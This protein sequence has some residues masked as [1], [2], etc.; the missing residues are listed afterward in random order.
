MVR[1]TG[2]GTAVVVF[3][4]EVFPPRDW[5]DTV[6]APEA[7]AEGTIPPPSTVEGDRSQTDR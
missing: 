1:R 2:R 6:R 5:R 4:D 7:L 3:E